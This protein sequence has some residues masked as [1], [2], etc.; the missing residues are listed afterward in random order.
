MFSSMKVVL[1]VSRKVFAE[2]IS[3]FKVARGY[4]PDQKNL[5]VAWGWVLSRYLPTGAAELKFVGASL[6]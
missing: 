5:R 3:S 2:V 4:S 1:G 6:E